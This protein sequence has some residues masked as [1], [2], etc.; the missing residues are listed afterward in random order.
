MTAA[1]KTLVVLVGNLGN[2]KRK[3][4]PLND[5]MAYGTVDLDHGVLPF[6]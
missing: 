3:L 6:R 5:V 4:Q 1:V 2:G